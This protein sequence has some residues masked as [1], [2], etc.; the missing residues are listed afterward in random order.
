[1]TTSETSAPIA[2]LQEIV[3]Q[4]REDVLQQAFQ[5]VLARHGL[6]VA[7]QHTPP[8]TYSDERMLNRETGRFFSGMSGKDGI[9]LYTP[10]I[11]EREELG[12]DYALMTLNVTIHERT[13]SLCGDQHLPERTTRVNGVDMKCHIEQT[14]YQLVMLV[15]MAEGFRPQLIGS[16]SNM[17]LNEGVT[18]AFAREVMWQYLKLHPTFAGVS[19]KKIHAHWAA[20]QSSHECAYYGAAVDFVRALARMLG[21]T[22][23]DLA[24]EWAGL[25]AD[26]FRHANLHTD[27]SWQ[28]RFRACG[29]EGIMLSSAG[30]SYFNLG[31]HT[32]RLELIMRTAQ[33]V[34]TL[35]SGSPA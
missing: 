24:G 6:D 4:I 29:I 21:S 27:R 28:E 17:W 14:G 22:S 7:Q 19:K 23:G 13:H 35:E 30:C 25:Y 1:M 34:G 8:L 33:L 12:G 3:G 15:H 32:R 9:T 18:E 5:V 10:G 11:S 16:H 20:L 26:Y 31:E 2:R